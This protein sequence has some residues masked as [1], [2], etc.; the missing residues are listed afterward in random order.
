M[1]LL[2]W[3]SLRRRHITALSLL[4][5]VGLLKH[6]RSNLQHYTSVHVTFNG[7]P[8]SEEASIT[9]HTSSRAYGMSQP[10]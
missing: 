5:A 1:S 10:R 3:R 4:G 7:V 6:F 2:P 8:L 9:R